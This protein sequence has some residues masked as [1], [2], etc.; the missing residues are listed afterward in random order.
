MNSSTLRPGTGRALLPL[1]GI[2]LALAGC[3]GGDDGKGG[4]SAA[5]GARA[6]LVSVD[7]GRLVD[8]YAYR[9]TD[10]AAA[11]RVDATRRKTVRVETETLINPAIASQNLADDRDAT[12]R[13]LPFDAQ[14]G[15]D[16]LLILWDDTHPDEQAAFD[17]ALAE[18]RV[19]LVRVAKSHRDQ[20]TN[21]KPMPVIPRNAAIQLTFDR[22]LG[23]E[24]AYFEA[25]PGAVQVL[26]V[27]ADP[28]TSAPQDAYIPVN[29]RTIAKGRVLIVDPTLIGDE[30]G[31]GQPNSTGL[32]ASSDEAANLRIAMPIT[33]PT[34]RVFRVE[35]DAA[36]EFS[37]PD[38]R[39]EG[40]EGEDRGCHH[41]KAH[42]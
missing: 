17:R 37:G 19:G 42:G 4:Q 38:S 15:H 9:R 33:G 27:I 11:N 29:V 16:E 34:S 28:K 13:F 30:I 32:P 6:Q 23:L 40:D 12:Y 21:T 24:S 36:P 20:N 7:Y 2:F 39:G 14:V 22:P 10:P 3:N 25:N 41:E 35:T 31:N 5:S 26:R 8:I 18:A 1:T